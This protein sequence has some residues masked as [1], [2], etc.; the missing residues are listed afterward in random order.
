MTAVVSRR[1]AILAFLLALACRSGAGSLPM[2]PGPT[3]PVSGDQAI[4]FHRQAEIFYRLL[5]QRRFNT[6]ETFND[7]RLRE[8]FESEDLFFDYY[9]DLAQSLSEA[10]FDKSRPRRAE[11][12]EFAFEERG[13]VRVQVLFVGDDDRPLRPGRVRLVRR[14]R[15][16]EH[17]GRWWIVPG[18]L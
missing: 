2:P 12:Q 13:Q 3:P 16:R 11:L 9:A 8:H 15:W 18:K 5:I 4:A 10:N 14:D 7:R 6:L 17:E 1:A